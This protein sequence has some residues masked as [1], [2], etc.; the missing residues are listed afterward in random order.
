MKLKE[1]I[2]ISW[3]LFAPIALKA[4]W[5]AEVPV[6]VDITYLDLVNFL[7]SD[8]SNKIRGQY[9]IIYGGRSLVI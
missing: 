4:R 3:S 5:S 7:I 8:E 6:D 1:G 2:N 9:I